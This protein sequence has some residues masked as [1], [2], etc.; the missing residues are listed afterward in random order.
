[1]KLKNSFLSSL[2]AML[3]AFS[4]PASLV[5][6]AQDGAAPAPAATPTPKGRWD[7]EVF[8]ISRNEKG[9]TV[10]RLATPAE[11][12]HLAQPEKARPGRVLIYPGARQPQ[13]E[14]GDVTSPRVP[15]TDSGQA[16]MP[17]AGLNIVL[18]GTTNL[19]NNIAAR[20]AFI[21]AANRWEALISTQMTVVL[22]VD[23]GPDFFG[24]P[25]SSPQVLGA[26]GTAESSRRYS[27]VRQQLLAASP[28]A[29]ETTLYNALPA[30][31]VP[32]EL[33]GAPAS[34]SSVRLTAT[35]ARALGIEPDITNP[36]ALAI[37]QG[38][39]SARSPRPS[40]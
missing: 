17:S 11:R 26:T 18:H 27:T 30:A 36:D 10:C 19:N 1:V 3:L 40:A 31:N 6:A 7:S 2:L 34:A 35:V 25:Y 9:E 15:Q 12:R 22:D 32:V 16:L 13:A 28:T 39:A 37:G 4:G 5:V 33:N 24:Q 8:I 29:A 14:A 21:V 20:D 23:F 38:A